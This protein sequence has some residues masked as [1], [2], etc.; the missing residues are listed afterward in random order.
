MDEL[1]LGQKIKQA[2]LELRLT[3]QE[4]AGDFITRNMLSK[5]E[6]DVTNPSLK[7]IQYLAKRLNKPIS[8]FLNNEHDKA[9]T[10]DKSSKSFF[11]HASFLTKNKEYNKC[12]N[13]INQDLKSSEE[14]LQNLYHGRLLYILAKCKIRVD[15]YNSVDNLLDNA[16]RILET[17]NDYYY[18]SNTYFYKANVFFNDDKFEKSETYIKEAIKELRKSHI[19][20]ILLEIK[21]FFSLGFT[22]YKQNKYEESII[23]LNYAIELS[24]EYKAFNNYGE[25]HM[26]LGI[27]YKR[28]NE[29]D[30]AIGYTKKA[31]SIFHALDDNYSKAACQ[32]N[33]GNYYLIISDFS[34]AEKYLNEALR[35]FDENKNHKITHTI[36]SDIQELLVKKGDYEKAIK[37]IDEIDINSVKRVDQARVYMNLGNSYMGIKNY[38]L[39]EDKL[40]KAEELLKDSNH[41]DV[42]HLIYDSYSHLYS[43]LKDYEKAYIYSEKSKEFLKHSFNDKQVSENLK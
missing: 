2:R 42:L 30:K 32:K 22:L 37:Y 11:E 26:L 28:I 36:R 18:L 4:V 1:T 40:R 21:L 20:D 24:E 31:I 6:H 29:M 43:S 10:I 25:A 12:I 17:N 15:D 34:N 3:Q 39:A 9:Q 27:M 8:Y 23:H 16:I 5:I 33:I 19:D 41:F 14:E 35:Y 7:T 38:T 13:Y